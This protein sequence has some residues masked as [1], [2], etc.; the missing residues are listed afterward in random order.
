MFVGL[1]T[2]LVNASNQTRWVSLINQ[3][4][5]TQ[6]TLINLHPNECTLE[7]HYYPL[8]FKLDISVASCNTLNDSSNKVCVPKK[9]CST[10]LQK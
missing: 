3:K 8:P 2:G 9:S 7:L 6:L 4:Y 10:W 1:L 5:N